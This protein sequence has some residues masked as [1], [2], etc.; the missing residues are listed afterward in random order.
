MRIAVTKTNFAT[1]NPECFIGEENLF[2]TRGYHR[3]VAITVK[4]QTKRET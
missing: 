2:L 3:K 1:E 4:R